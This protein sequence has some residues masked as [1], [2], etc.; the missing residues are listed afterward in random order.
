[1]SSTAMIEELLKDL[2]PYTTTPA[3]SEA[4][5]LSG[6]TLLKMASDGLI[7]QPVKV[8]ARKRLW[9]TAGVREALIKR[10]AEGAVSHAG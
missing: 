5:Q 3:L 4:L 7:P 2:E 6:R 8:G 1:M 9:N 10:Q